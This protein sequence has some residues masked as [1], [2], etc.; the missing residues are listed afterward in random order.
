MK[1]QVFI[2][3]G[4]L[5]RNFCRGVRPTQRNPDPVQDTKDVRFTTLSKRKCCNFLPCSR[6]DQAGRI[7]NTKNGTYKFAFSHIPTKA[8]EISENYVI[9]GGDKEKIY[10]DDPV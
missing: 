8:H 1:S 6:L 4:V 7:Q 3:G 5:N 2:P 9:E 10:G